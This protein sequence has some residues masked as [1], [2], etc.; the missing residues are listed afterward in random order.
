MAKKLYYSIKEVAAQFGLKESTLRYWETEFDEIAPR[1]KNGVRYYTDDDIESIRLI[2]HLV[3]ERGMTLEGARR[4]LRD[5]RETTI[6]QTD[7]IHRMK[8]IRG[9][10]MALIGALDEMEKV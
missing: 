1:K 2:H 5:N 8:T 7:V 9:E 4:K 6:N 3:R 10:I